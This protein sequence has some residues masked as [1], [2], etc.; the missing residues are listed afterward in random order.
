MIVG[1]PKEVKT[2]EYRVGLVPSA[3]TTLVNHGHR[4]L[5]ERGAGLGSGTSDEEYVEQ[6]A[7]ILPDATS[8]YGAAEMIVKVKEPQP[9]E[10]ELLQRG[11][12]LF[13]Y[14]HLAPAP[15]LT[16]G[17]LDSGVIGIAYETIQSP[18]GQLPC[19]QPMSEV[20]G[21]MSIQAGA[22]CLE[23]ESGG[24]G[25]LLGGVPG[26]EP[27]TVVILGGGSVGTNAAQMAVG[28]GADVMIMDIDLQRLRYLDDIFGGRI[29]TQFSNPL[30][31]AKM[32]ERADLVIGAVLV[33]G[34]RAPRLI[35]E[36]MVRGMKEGAV[37]VDV[38]VDQGG[39]A[40]TT[41]A[42][43]HDK[44]TFVR[45]GVVHYCVANMPGAVART[46]TFALNNATFPYA[47][48][49]ADKGWK[50]A[51]REDHS[52]FYGVNVV[53]GD[54]VYEPIARDLDL[55]YVALNL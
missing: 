2:H 40:E 39:I 52:L 48:A 36:D 30:T 3:V 22:H 38:A 29:R 53:D 28:L 42:T 55:P 37:I 49:I 5:V 45:H 19:L 18:D 11:Q 25:V 31:I 10:I 34:A 9:Q 14:L 44:P 1:V 17:L 46:S 35:T 8:V 51:V 13:T 6:G 15:E 7:E 33:T 21:R 47:I 24:R 20:A 50:Q 43:T 54:C 12:I 16:Q 23:K 32:L 26:V 4:V 27:G 41:H